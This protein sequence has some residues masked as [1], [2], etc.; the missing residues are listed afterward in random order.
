[1]GN[2]VADGSCG[3]SKVG[4]GVGHPGEK[5]LRCV[6][7]QPF[8]NVLFMGRLG[9]LRPAVARPAVGD[10]AASG[11]HDLEQCVRSNRS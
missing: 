5:T 7:L 8:C 4:N 6:H 11:T 9:A 2:D 10:E 1:V 3:V